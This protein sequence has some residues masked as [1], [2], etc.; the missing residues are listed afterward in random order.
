[1]TPQTDAVIRVGGRGRQLQRLTLTA[2]QMLAPTAVPLPA[3]ATA[4]CHPA[5]PSILRPGW[6]AGVVLL[7][8]DV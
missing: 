1:M 4:W 7:P 6:P 3:Q 2:R 5:E 8:G